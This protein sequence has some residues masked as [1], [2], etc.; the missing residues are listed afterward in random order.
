MR[1]K[2]SVR[3]GLRAADGTEIILQKTEEKLLWGGLLFCVSVCV[4]L[5]G[6]S[7]GRV[8]SLFF[9]LRQGFSV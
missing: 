1:G 3:A 9:L 5:L 7:G 4:C 2:D 6:F 8:V